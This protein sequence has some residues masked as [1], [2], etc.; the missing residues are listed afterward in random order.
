MV[1]PTTSPS[2]SLPGLRFLDFRFLSLVLLT[3]FVKLG[4]HRGVATGEPF[5]GEVVGLVVGQAQV[6]FGADEGVLDLLEMGNGLVYLVDRGLELL[7]GEAI[8][9]AEGVFES[10]ELVFKVGDIHALAAG[11][12]KLA[13]VVHRLL[14]G[15]HQ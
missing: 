13:L 6:V 4:F 7:A 8:V 15:I 1:R 12:R 2:I 11:N 5:D 14:G 9:A 10:Q 3:G